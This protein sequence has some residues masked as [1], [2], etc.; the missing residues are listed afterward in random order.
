[1]KRVN[2]RRAHV[3]LAILCE[4]AQDLIGRDVVCG[5]D[6]LEAARALVADVLHLCRK[7]HVAKPITSVVVEGVKQFRKED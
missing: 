5:A 3:A 2:V 1:M 7:E 4:H 6:Q